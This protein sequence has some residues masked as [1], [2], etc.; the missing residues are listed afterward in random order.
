[1]SARKIII[2]RPSGTTR[3]FTLIELRKT[4]QPDVTVAADGNQPA[5]DD[6]R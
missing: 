1:M 2:R 3:R 6:S 5:G 4:S